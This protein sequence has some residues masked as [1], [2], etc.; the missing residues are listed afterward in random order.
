M[1]SQF[2]TS[3][4]RSVLG[5]IWGPTLENDIDFIPSALVYEI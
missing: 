1:N 3:D 2:D 4:S 5:Y